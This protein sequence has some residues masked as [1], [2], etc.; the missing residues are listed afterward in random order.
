MLYI[1]VPGT[2]RIVHTYI[3][4]RLRQRTWDQWS[5]GGLMANDPDGTVLLTDKP[6]HACLEVAA[7]SNLPQ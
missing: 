1:Q 3:T 4:T 2:R 7:A 6:E 5:W